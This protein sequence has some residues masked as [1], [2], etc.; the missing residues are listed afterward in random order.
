M[1]EPFEIL[2][3][4]ETEILVDATRTIAHARRHTNKRCM[5]KINGDYTLHG[6]TPSVYIALIH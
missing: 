6:S 4:S 5:F 1:L 3:R 2:K